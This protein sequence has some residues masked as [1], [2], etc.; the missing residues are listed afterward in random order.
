MEEAK[1]LVKGSRGAGGNSGIG[2]VPM[3]YRGRGC[4]FN[5]S[6]GRSHEKRRGDFDAVEQKEALY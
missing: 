5:S 1:K 3:R 4:C 2:A 6:S